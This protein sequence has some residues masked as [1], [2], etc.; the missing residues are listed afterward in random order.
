MSWKLRMAENS[1]FAILL[2][3]PW[4]ASLSIA[5]L[6]GVVS[7]AVLPP[8]WRVVGVLSGFPF[9]VL[10]A[11][12]AWRQRQ[13][14]NAT[15]VAAVQSAVSAMAWPAFATHLEAAF[16]RDGFEVQAG[17]EAPVDYVLARQGRPMLVCARRWKSAQTG[18]DTLRAL[19][20]AREAHAEQPA[21]A[22][23]LSLGSLSDSARAFAAQHRIAVWQAPEIAQ[24]LRDLRT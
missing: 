6:M 10:A 13:L 19:Q 5:L 7:M 14:P 23:V 11:L 3:K 12:A 8:D 21:D 1:I 9:V 16:R 20:Q 17:R 2:R 15:R 4:W 22:L 24:A 18:L